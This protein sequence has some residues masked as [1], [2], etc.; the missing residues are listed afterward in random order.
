MSVAT[1]EHR[2]APSAAQTTD[3]TEI[4]QQLRARVER[5]LHELQRFLAAW[6]VTS[7][8]VQLPNADVGALAQQRSQ[9]Q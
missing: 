7:P 2:I 8:G 1:K 3:I 9:R 5:Q 4:V 6:S